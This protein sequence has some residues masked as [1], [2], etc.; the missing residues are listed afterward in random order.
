MDK[1]SEIKKKLNR[2]KYRRLMRRLTLFLSVIAI[3]FVMGYV[4]YT[5]HNSGVFSIKKVEISG[6]QLVTEPEILE[7]S[8]LA[9]GQSIFSINV[10]QVR[11]KISE[12]VLSN[13]VQ[14]RRILPDTIHMTVQEVPCLYV[15]YSDSTVH[16]M[17]KDDRLIATSSQL[18]NAEV[19]VVSGFKEVQF[20]GVG[21][22]AEISTKGQFNKIRDLIDY[23]QGE[24]ML[25]HIS[26]IAIA[27]QETVHIVTKNNILIQVRDLD[28]YKEHVDYIQHVIE[29]KK[30]DLTINLTAGSNPVIKER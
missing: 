30:R 17:D 19:P 2:I 15:I 13:H 20:R 5:A 4:I 24:K 11:Y 28:N 16:Y 9:M 3:L 21:R 23:F 7:K 29:T 26:E 25:N 6:N 22:T 12:L 14:I 8:G 10:N 1:R 27:D 18:R